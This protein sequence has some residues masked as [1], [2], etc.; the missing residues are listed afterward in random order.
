[1]TSR[2]R[3]AH[4]VIALALLVQAALI[5]SVEQPGVATAFSRSSSSD[6]LLTTQTDRDFVGAPSDSRRASHSLDASGAL[7]V[8]NLLLALLLACVVV[9][10]TSRVPG[11]R[12]LRAES[13][14]APPLSAA[15]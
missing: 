9:A 10:R 3:W 13:S 15:I 8:T 11:T 12:P 14:R 6:L 1:M 5:L 2:R 4:A 7:A